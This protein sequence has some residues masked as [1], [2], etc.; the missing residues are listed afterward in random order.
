MVGF[1]IGAALFAM[2]FFFSLYLQTVL[3]YDALKA[4]FG[5]L[6]VS[7]GI[8][9]SAAVVSQLANTVSP[10]LLMVVGLAVL[11]LGLV[12]FSASTADGSYLAK[13]LFPGLVMS[14]GL[15]MTFVP[16]T[17]FAV[18][19]VPPEEAGLASGLLNTTQ[20]VGGALGLA[21]LS[22][23]S[24]TKADDVLAGIGAPPSPGQIADAL[25]QGYSAGPVVGAAFAVAGLLVAILLIRG[26]QV[27]PQAAPPPLG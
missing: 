8:I 21:V 27:D 17:L 3:G 20:Q 9:V 4:G 15:G 7:I 26:K 1:V 24:T 25:T 22:T 14:V 19:G 6:P 2:F 5:S 11:A 18:S 12:W 10:K 13:V 16:L 23:V